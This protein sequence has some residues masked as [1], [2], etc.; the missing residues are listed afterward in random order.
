MYYDPSASGSSTQPPP[1]P[2]RTPPP[3]TSHHPYI[4]VPYDPYG[5]SQLPHTSYD[6]YAHAPSPPIC[7]P[8][9]DRTQYFCKTHILLDEVSGPGL[10]LSAQFFKQL[11]ASIPMD[12]SYSSAGYGAIDCGIASSDHGDDELVPVAHASSSG[13]RPALGRGEGVDW[14]F[15][16]NHE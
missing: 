1:I 12:S 11:V 9:Q 4:P 2:F 13:C 10:Q 15:H 16:V 14:Q 5:Y 6:P 3:T 8:S 7:M